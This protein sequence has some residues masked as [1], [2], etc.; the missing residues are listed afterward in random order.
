METCEVLVVG[1]GPAGSSCAGRLRQAG[2]DV[3]L[4]DMQT[5]PRQKPCAGW[6]TPT[7]LDVLAID[8]EEYRQGRVFQDIS[9]FRTGLIN[10]ASIVTHYDT[11]VS[12]GVRRYEFDNYLLQRS[13]VRVSLGDP[14]TTLE[15]IADGWIVN[16]RIK[17][18]LLVGAGGHFCPVARLL[19][20]HIGREEVVAAQV[21]EFA[22]STNEQRLCRIESDTP[23]LFF[24]RDMKGY[25]WLFR[26][27]TYL[28]IGLGR[29][30]T[31]DLVRHTREFCLFL[32]QQK[33]LSADIAPDFNGHAYRAYQGQGGRK[34]VA[35]GALLI[36]DAAGV[37]HSVSGEGI[38][39]SIESAM[40]AADT[41]CAA[42]GDYRCNNLDPYMARLVSRYGGKKTGISSSPIFSGLSRF[43]GAR[44]LSSKSFTRHV[45][46]NRWFLHTH[47]DELKSS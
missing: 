16:G 42:Q 3:L 35:D 37:A 9:S 39:P 11:T 20:A 33:Y 26:K 28:N 40:M 22:M 15:R 23:A 24:C 43:I 6:I 27:G 7:V 32:K 1:G 17:A 25:G 47:L 21:A 13:R 46:F 10:G 31:C 34:C 45:V 41:I 18:R 2:L 38:L 14:V 5:F 4:L 12:Y 19:G 8:A 36:G 30:D 44:L 29:M